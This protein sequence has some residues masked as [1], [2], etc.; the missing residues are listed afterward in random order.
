[1]GIHY[2]YSNTFDRKRVSTNPI[3]HPNPKA[4][5]SNVFGLTKLRYFSR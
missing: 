1:M 5:V 3:P 4:Q 2:T